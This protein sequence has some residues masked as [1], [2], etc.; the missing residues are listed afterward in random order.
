MTSN[1]EDYLKTIY[2]EGGLEKS[3]PN[4]VISD[5]LGIAPAS[6]SEMLSKL[7][8]QGLIQYEAYK[9]SKLTEMGLSTCMEVVRSHRLWE[10]FLMRHLRYTWREAHEEAHLLEHIAPIRMVNRLDAFLN[11][12]ETCPHGSLIPKNGTIPENIELKKMS[13]LS[14]GDVATVIR[15]IEEGELL[16]Y[17]ERI[18]L[19]IGREITIFSKEEYEGA[20]TF[21]Q[22]GNT[23]RIS[24][25][26]A[27][28]V[29]VEE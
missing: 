7:Q 19:Q 26:A 18:G 21:T 10:V 16:D 14:E 4:K 1:K 28:Q 8:K 6:V 17:L 13:D 23:I 2:E 29:Y 24:Y 20:I 3:V 9:G 5:K 11:Y 27:S 12:P 25:K 15:M 22:D